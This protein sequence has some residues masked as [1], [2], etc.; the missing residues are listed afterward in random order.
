MDSTSPMTKLRENEEERERGKEYFII[1]GVK[2]LRKIKEY[3]A[4]YIIVVL[5]FI[6]L[7]INY[8]VAYSVECS[9]RKP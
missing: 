1:Y 8:K 5:F 9:D 7:S 6:I 4:W 3:A 2:C